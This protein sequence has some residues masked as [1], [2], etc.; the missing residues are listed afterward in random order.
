[1]LGLNQILYTDLME[2]P[3]DLKSAVTYYTFG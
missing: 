2:R 3:I 1:M